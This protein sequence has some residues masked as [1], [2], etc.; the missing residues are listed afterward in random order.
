MTSRS[1]TVEKALDRL[2]PEFKRSSVAVTEHAQDIN[3]AI[4]KV[5]NEIGEV[6]RAYESCDRDIDKVVIIIIYSA[7]KILFKV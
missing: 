2:M 5:T 3:D 6:K 7:L 4:I 1:E